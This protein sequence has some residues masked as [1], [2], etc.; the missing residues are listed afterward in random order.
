MHGLG[1][2][3]PAQQQQ[4]LMLQQAAALN[5]SMHRSVVTAADGL[6]S[7]SSHP[8]LQ[9]L[10][11]AGSSNSSMMSQPGQHL[12]DA[13]YTL[14]NS[15]SL[16]G[17]GYNEFLSAVRPTAL[18]LQQQQQQQLSM[19]QLQLQRPMSPVLGGGWQRMV[20]RM[21]P[22]GQN[23]QQ[24]QGHAAL[25]P[26]LLS[27]GVTTPGPIFLN[28]QGKFVTSDNQLAVQQQ[29]QQQQLGVAHGSAF[30]AAATPGMHM[31]S[32]EN[33][34]LLEQ[35]QH[36]QQQHQQQQHQ[37]QMMMM[38]LNN[39]NPAYAKV[40]PNMHLD[41]PAAPPNSNMLLHMQQQQQQQLAPQQLQL[42][43]T[44][45]AAAAAAAM[46]QQEAAAAAAADASFISLSELAGGPQEGL[47]AVSKARAEAA[48]PLE[49]GDGDSKR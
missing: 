23:L 17:S 11:N 33:P 18:Q 47:Y 34:W 44:P 26:A 30:P 25:N 49:A 5:S 12:I 42:Q 39:S 40:R 3:T 41:P 22:P 31:L 2:L 4:Q 16:P 32:A 10:Y 28:S 27:R 1:G 9:Q 45:A 38:Q 14:H 29:Q 15:I 6:S 48:L 21:P 37:Q 35:Q 13:S 43:T 46:A 24:Q 19:A 20:D 7:S 8:T 36:Q